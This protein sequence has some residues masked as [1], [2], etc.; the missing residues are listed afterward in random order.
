MNKSYTLGF[1]LAK[2]PSSYK[3]MLSPQAYGC[4]TGLRS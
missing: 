4:L 2:K 1:L 3:N